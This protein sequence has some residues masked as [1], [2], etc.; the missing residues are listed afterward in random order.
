MRILMLTQ[1]FNPEPIFKGLTFAKELVRRGHEVEVLTGFP[2]YPGGEIYQGYRQRLWQREVLDD[3]PVVR[4]PLYASHDSSSFRRALNYGSFALSSASLG[5]GLIK[6]PDVMYVYQPITIGLAAT[7]IKY[8]RQTPF[9]IDI[10]DLWPEFLPATG[11]IN[12]KKALWLIGKWCEFVYRQASRVTT[13]SPG[14][15][16]AIVNRGIPADKVEVVYNWCDERQVDLSGICDPIVKTKLGSVVFFL[17]AE[18]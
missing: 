7:V 3:I 4:V 14:F 13:L 10:Q 8:L 16:E 1:W 18:Q 6:R 2:N 5:A 12:N 17:M 15:K 11:M 9:V